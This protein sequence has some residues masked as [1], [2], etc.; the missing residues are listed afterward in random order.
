M[1]PNSRPHVT[2]AW[3]AAALL[4][5]LA[6]GLQPITVNADDPGVAVDN[7]WALPAFRLPGLD[8]REH[9]LA[10]W[11]GRVILLNF[12]ATWCP[13][14]QVEVPDL[15]DY[16]ARYADQGLSVVSIGLDE[17]RKLRNFVRSLGINY[18][19]LVADGHAN[20]GLLRVWGNHEGTL[21]YSVVIDR[22]GHLVYGKAGILNRA[23]VETYV[24]PLLQ[25]PAPGT[26]AGATADI[27]VDQDGVLP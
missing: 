9:S 10:D 26:T 20:L 3:R 13:P 4:L 8:G 11:K 6:G 12:W 2:I 18:T 27:A 1:Y 5:C 16:Q 23:N 15:I 19:V 25:S 17:E 14:C 7:A 24:L 22:D 21:P